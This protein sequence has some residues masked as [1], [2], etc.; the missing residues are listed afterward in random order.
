MLTLPNESRAINANVKT[1]RT[2]RTFYYCN[3]RTPVALNAMEA[4]A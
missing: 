3:R 2:A 4:S 1:V